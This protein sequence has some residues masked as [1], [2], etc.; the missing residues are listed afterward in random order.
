M[1]ERTQNTFSRLRGGLA[2]YYEALTVTAILLLL[3]VVII[4]SGNS[5]ELFHPL[6]RV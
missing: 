4:L 5:P 1:K 3:A 6:I 2:E